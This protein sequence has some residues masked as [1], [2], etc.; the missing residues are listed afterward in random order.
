M[1]VRVREEGMSGRFPIEDLGLIGNCQ[2]SALV[3]RDGTIPWCC[4][5]Q[6]DSEPV[7]G[8]LLDE[9]EGGSFGVTPAAGEKGT[10]AYLPNTNVIE[11]TFQTSDGSFR[12][13]DFAPRYFH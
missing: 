3:A 9:E 8:A 11:T 4:L 1:P 5:P 2:M 10:Q 13:V 6:F 7:F 12:V